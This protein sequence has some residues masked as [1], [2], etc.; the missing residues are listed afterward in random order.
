MSLHQRT[1]P[2][3]VILWGSGLETAV[4]L[5]ASPRLLRAIW[6]R[7]TRCEVLCG[8]A[9][10]TVGTLGF[11]LWRHPSHYWHNNI[12]ATLVFT[13]RRTVKSDVDHNSRVRPAVVEQWRGFGVHPLGTYLPL[14]TIDNSIFLNRREQ[15][16]AICIITTRKEVC[17][18]R[19]ETGGGGGRHT[20]GDIPL[21]MDTTT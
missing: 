7:T 4:C 1:S 18:G 6:L 14:L 15:L 3:D 11:I 5:A 9:E 10:D 12:K 16:R 21:T 20:S 8:G 2:A 17:C 19:A 13:Q